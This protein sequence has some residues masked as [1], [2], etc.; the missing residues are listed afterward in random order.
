MV[1]SVENSIFLQL[2]GGSVG[3]GS[4][5]GGFLRLSTDILF[6][7]SAWVPAP[8]RAQY[9]NSKASTESL[10]G[11]CGLVVMA[12]RG[13]RGCWKPSGQLMML[14]SSY[15]DG[16]VLKGKASFLGM[17]L[18]SPPECFC[19]LQTPLARGHGTLRGGALSIQVKKCSFGPLA[20]HHVRHHH[21][22]LQWPERTEEQLV[23]AG[24]QPLGT[25]GTILRDVVYVLS[26]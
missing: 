9:A 8:L 23:L 21:V 14:C 22:P 18:P 1:H 19:G 2:P 6:L 15:R 24:R 13:G 20:S 7:K 12:G 4:G 17:D 3:H 16:S 5:D 25:L 26:Q 11:C 10:K